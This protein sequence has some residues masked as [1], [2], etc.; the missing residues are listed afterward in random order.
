MPLQNNLLALLFTI[1]LLVQSFE[2]VI[3]FEIQS[4]QQNGELELLLSKKGI[5]AE[6]KGKP[7][8]TVLMTRDGTSA[9]ELNAKTKTYREVDLQDQR[10]LSASIGKLEK[11]EVE[12]LGR[13]KIL[14][15]ACHHFKLKSSKRTIEVWA[16]E[17]LADSTLLA[18]VA[19]IGVIIG[20]SPNAIETM[21]KENLNGF[22]LKV[23]LTESSGV[24]RIEA[25]MIQRKSFKSSLFEVP[26]SY[27]EE[28]NHSEK[29]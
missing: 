21:Q 3:S 15:I 9:F 10:R 2:G 12:K 8:F 29:Q 1:P 4:E 28:G 5:R 14:N 26:K 7:A 23:I 17:S 6:F 11:F 27:R 13:E 22:P 18:R 24:A 16:A 19:D 20:I 25:K